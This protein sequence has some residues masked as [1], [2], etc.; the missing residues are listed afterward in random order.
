MDA[1]TQ[2]LCGQIHMREYITLLKHDESLQKQLRTLVPEEA[3]YNRGCPLWKSISYDTFEYCNFDLFC[4]LEHLFKFD[5]SIGDNLNIHSII[6]GVYVFCNPKISVTTLYHDSFNLLLDVAGECFGGPEVDG[7]IDAVICKALEKYR[8][9]KDRRQYAKGQ[10]RELFHVEKNKLPCWIHGPEW[11]MGCNSPM[12]YIS[13]HKNKDREGKV[14]VFQ[15]V[16]T[17][18]IRQVVEMY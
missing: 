17:G 16:D 2:M 1:L 4:V 8:T 12:K 18:E 14:F 10:I 15:D 11:P 7:L 3:R 13:T 6:S 9:K 5:G